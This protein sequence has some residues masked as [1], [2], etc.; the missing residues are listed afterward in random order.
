MAVLYFD[1]GGT[2]AEAS[3]G[4]D[5][6]FRFRPLPRVREVL[7]AGPPHRLGIISNPGADPAAP[8]RAAAALTATFGDIFEGALIHWGAKTSRTIFDAAVAA[9]GGVADDCVFLGEEPAERAMAR[10]VGMRTAP[11]PVFAPAAVRGDTVL[12]ARIHLDEQHTS[13][14]L[15]TVADASEIVPVHLAADQMVLAMVTEQGVRAAQEAGFTVDPEA[16]V[17]DTAA[18]LVRD[19]RPDSPPAR[20]DSGPDRP[21]AGPGRPASTARGTTGDGSGGRPGEPPSTPEGFAART[22]GP[23]SA[24]DAARRRAEAVLDFVAG[25]TDGLKSAVTLLGPAAGGAYLCADAET[26]V[27]DIHI[28]DTGHGHTER[29]LADPNLLPGAEEAPIIVGGSG[30]ALDGAL[31]AIRE[32][33]TAPAL[34]GHVARLSG[35]APLVDGAPLTVRGRDA[36]SADNPRVTTALAGRFTSLGF[37]VRLHRF[38]WRGH[39]LDNVEAQL[40]VPGTDAVLITAHLDSTAANGDFVDDAGNPRRYRPG[41]DPAPGADDDGSGT[42]GVLCAAECLRALVSAGRQPNR[43]IRFVLFNAEEQGLVGS[44]AYARAAAAAGDRIAAVFQM[45]MIA[46]FQG[47]TRKVELHAGSTVPGPAAIGSAALATMLAEAFATAAPEFEV[48]TLTVNDPAAGR[49]DHASFHERGWAAVC[50]SENFFA[51]TAPA[52]GTRRYHQPGDTV[53]D[54]DHDAEYAASIAR[55]VTA[56]ALT[57]AGL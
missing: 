15:R 41:V 8:A 7:A 33:I 16:E 9:A 10:R 5:G 53:H 50:V 26:V 40:E 39:L 17:G 48:E 32:A 6:S 54:A 47:G 24:G 38:S 31:E 19:D 45:D 49:S 55:A 51:D 43:T 42:A 34:R 36:A 1:I 35:A 30:F 23:E 44:K 56:T 20:S 22:G 25:A 2:L 4:A 52:T 11:H 46:G 27:E 13:A 28:P 12:W 29:L 37:A 57:L 21:D 18:F 14:R 3:V